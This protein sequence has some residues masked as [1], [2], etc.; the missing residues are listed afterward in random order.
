MIHFVGAG[1]GAA[2]L[3]T[4]RGQSLINDADVIIYAGSLVNPDILKYAKDT[5]VIYDSKN[6]TLPEV[7]SVMK[8]ADVK[9]LSVVRLHTGEPS[10][11]G[12][13]REQMDELDELGIPYD[14]CP[15]VTAAFGAAA[16]LNM[17]YT[18][19]DVSQSLIITRMEGRT[20]VPSGE[21]I[22]SFA[23]HKAS[24]AIYLSSGMMAEL[25]ARLINGG[26]APDT[27]AAIVYKATWPEEKRIVTTVERLAESAA[28]N[29]I[30]NLAVVLVGDSVAHTGYGKSKLY[31]PEFTTAFRTAED[32]K[33]AQTLNESFHES[34]RE[35]DESAAFKKGSVKGIV[36]N[37][38]PDA[39]I[40][41]F[42]ENGEKLSERIRGELGKLGAEAVC[43][44]CRFDEVKKR[45]TYSFN[46][47]RAV[48][49]IGAAG[50][51]VRCISEFVNDKFTDSPVIVISEDGRFVI[52]ILSGHIGGGNRLAA[53]LADRIGAFKA[54]TTSTDI[55]GGFQLDNFASSHFLHIADR[56]I[57]KE[58]AAKG[59]DEKC[60]KDYIAAGKL[61]PK[62][63]FLG[64]GCR[65]GKSFEDIDKAVK[66]F[67]AE[68]DVE[69]SRIAMIS[70]ID[71][72]RNEKGI[73]Q[74]AD[75][76]GLRFITY[77][78]EQL[79]ALGSGFTV[80]RAVLERV[81]VDNVCERAAVAAAV[82]F[83]D[84]ADV[85][86]NDAASKKE[87]LNEKSNAAEM[88]DCEKNGD[89]KILC[90]RRLVKSKTVYD[91]ITLA[92]A[93]GSWN[94]CD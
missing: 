61:M 66:E 41:S 5:A 49:F 43:F 25:S 44:R 42:S 54:I 26:Y 78:A 55:N 12:A 84:A 35:S 7:I 37:E 71:V 30:K 47:K 46:Y 18:L 34:L 1:P 91:G 75:K 57:I 51:A 2:D 83:S 89:N 27:P 4:L 79:A 39:D 93:E 82:Q 67:L 53:S 21:S 86:G 94:I 9:E 80:S 70:S 74:F 19:P 31:S 17:E 92:L 15:G 23:A 65:R 64:I 16:A 33:A 32:D 10:I 52:P 72:K 3:I 60:I 36:V 73:R 8:E 24:M 38:Y 85:C 50:I 68:A 63:Y 90:G 14:S 22:E 45:L 58:A 11:Y 40:F 87:Q 29:N 48:I 81:G 56:C 6:M 13:V 77:T 59:Y 76:N 69:M 28:E 88:Q 62:Q 20:S